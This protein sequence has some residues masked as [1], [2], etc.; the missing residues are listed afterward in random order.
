MSI[1]QSSWL[2][3]NWWYLIP[4]AILIGTCIAVIWAVS[5]F[6]HKVSQVSDDL[7]KAIVEER[8]VWDGLDCDDKKH[9]LQG[10]DLS[11]N[12]LFYV[13]QNEDFYREYM[14]NCLPSE[15]IEKIHN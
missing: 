4:F 10:R 1:Y 13:S 5:D 3:N 15:L 8:K 6:Q 7:H 11:G 12:I 14:I 2:S 9:Y